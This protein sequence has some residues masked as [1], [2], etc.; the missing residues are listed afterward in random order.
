MAYNRYIGIIALS[1]FFAWV[2]WFLVVTRLSPFVSM[3]LS[4]SFF[5]LTLFIAL[6]CSFTV[7][8]FYFRVWLFKNEIFYSHIN[9]AFRQGILLSV[10]VM[11]C[12]ALQMLRVLNWW[13]GGFLIF[14]AVLL[15]SY[16]SSQDSEFIE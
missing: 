10:I 9:V 6:S 3:G 1:G 13:S 4:L 14:G 5:F 8:G 7:F 12:L 15:E 16:F 2:G 11:L